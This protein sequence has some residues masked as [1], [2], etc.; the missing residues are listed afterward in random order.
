MHVEHHP[1]RGENGSER[2]HDSEQREPGELEPHGWQQPE[3]E[4]G[5]DPDGDRGGG[6]DERGG[7]HGVNL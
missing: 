7:D 6:E 1:A 3:S 5:G 2:Q 4:R